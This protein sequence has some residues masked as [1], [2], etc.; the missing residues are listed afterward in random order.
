MIWIITFLGILIIISIVILYFIWKDE[1][2]EEKVKF[3]VPI[4]NKKLKIDDKLF[5]NWLKELDIKQEDFLKLK[6]EIRKKI[7]WLDEFIN[8]I[9]V[10]ILANGHLLVEW[11]P[12]LAKTKTIETLSY[13]LDVNFTRIQFTPDMLPSD[14]IWTEIYNQKL[15]DFETKLWPIFTNVLLADEINRTTPKVQSAL[16][17]AMQE[18]KVTIWWKNYSLPKPF[19]VLATQNPLEQEW[20][21]PL[22]EAQLDRF[23]FKVLVNYP[24][25]EEEIKILD[26]LEKE[27]NIKLE[28]ILNDEKIVD[29]Q[30]QVKN[31]YASEKMKEYIVKLVEKTREKD[32]RV[33]YGASP[34]WS[35]ALLNASKA[36]AF[37]EWRDYITYEDIQRVALNS[38][39][40]RI[41]ISYDAKIDWY[42]EDKILLEKLPEV[43][44]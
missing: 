25:R 43:E 21:Y 26:T 17:E 41:I 34:R 20:T 5:K 12:W 3:D 39:R 1:L 35:I 27:E 36:V 19:F 44:F 6:N 38:L 11:V 2:D 13:I 31:V 33:L 18:R 42:N 22:P 23:L 40:H 9:L 4:N 24:N 7:I 28:K 32:E 37:L 8:S 16:L 30:K 15:N 29:F 14:I 10:S